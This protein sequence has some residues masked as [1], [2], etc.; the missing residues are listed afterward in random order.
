MLINLG[1]VVDEAGEPVAD[2]AVNL[3]NLLRSGLLIQASARFGKSYGLRRLIEATATHA[4]HLL[5]DPEGEFSTLREAFA[6]VLV[7]GQGGEVVADPA[8]AHR[9]AGVLLELRANAIL[10]VS[11]LRRADRHAFVRCFAEGLMAARASAASAASFHPVIVTLD[12]AHLFCPEGKRS[13]SAEAVSDLCERGRKRG[14]CVVLAT[15]RVA[16]LQKNAAAELSSKL[17]GHMAMD[18]DVE[19]ERKALGIRDGARLRTLRVGEFYAVGQA[20][21]CPPES[22]MRF[23]PCHTKAPQPGHTYRPPP[24]PADVHGVLARLTAE[25]AASAAAESP[26]GVVRERVEVEVISPAT[27]VALEHHVGTV[28][29]LVVG[30]REDL[31]RVKALASDRDTHLLALMTADRARTPT[32]AP[33]ADPPSTTPTAAPPTSPPAKA[34]PSAPPAKPTPPPN[35]PPANAPPPAPRPVPAPPATAATVAT[36]PAP[37]RTRAP[38]KGAVRGRVVDAVAWLTALGLPRTHAAIGRL[39]QVSTTNSTL[40]N[41]LARLLQERLIVYPTK[42]EV[43]LTESGMREATKVRTPRSADELQALLFDVLGGTE[44]TILRALISAHPQALTRGELAAATA[45]SDTASTL[46]NNLARLRALS[47]IDNT[48]EG[49]IRASD[50]VFMQRRRRAKDTA[51]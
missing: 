21:E 40:R 39:A 10:D 8:T 35:A 27:L 37:T 23:G 2:F 24:L 6:F 30:L 33:V 4:Q 11:G 29:Q 25:L 32:P 22:V 36:K 3:E 28:E 51:A 1:A 15:Q 42:G 44:A 20:F 9:L 50:H 48:P 45:V 17:I 26:A 12:E 34:P 47:L 18:L 19:R 7:A 38:S 16:K 31:Q 13:E 46:R 43:A 41:N 5:I 14:L 49:S